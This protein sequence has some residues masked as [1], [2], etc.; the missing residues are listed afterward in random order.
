MS[1]QN[2]DQL[3]NGLLYSA[4]QSTAGINLYCPRNLSL[5]VTN[6]ILQICIPEVDKLTIR[7]K[8]KSKYVLWLSKK[9]AI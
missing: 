8:D 5:N 9:N 7:F 4:S 6:T 1:H 2:V 3:L